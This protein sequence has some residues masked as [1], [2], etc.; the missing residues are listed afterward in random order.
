MSLDI[1][2]TLQIFVE[3]PQPFRAHAAEC[4]PAS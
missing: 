1:L 2:F 4:F 3:A